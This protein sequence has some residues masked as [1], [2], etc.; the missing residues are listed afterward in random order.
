M[1][2]PIYLR[3]SYTKMRLEATLR[4]DIGAVR[5]SKICILPPRNVRLAE[6]FVQIR[7]D[8]LSS[9]TT[10]QNRLYLPLDSLSSCT[11]LGFLD[12]WTASAKAVLPFSSLSFVSAPLA[13]K[14]FTLSSPP[15][16][17]AIIKAV[18]PP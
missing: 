11:M 9:K 14:A 18:A 17:A 15:F 1:N 5:M 7:K 3:E 13:S 8:R 2:E 10:N 6:R 4:A 16:R 12:P